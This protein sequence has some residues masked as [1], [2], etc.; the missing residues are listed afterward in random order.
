[1]YAA[2]SPNWLDR[3][4]TIARIGDGSSNT[5]LFMHTYGLCPNKNGSTYVG[6]GS[7]WGYS[8][9]LGPTLKPPPATGV[10]IPWQRASYLGQT[11]MSTTVA[12][13]NAPNPVVDAM[14]IH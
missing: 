5:I 10:S 6:G 3:G 1:M 9:G 7:A 12:F 11:S 13:Q 4:S 8:A 14:P 2:G